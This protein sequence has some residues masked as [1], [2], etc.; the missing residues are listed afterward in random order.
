LIPAGIA[1]S[2]P[3]PW[4]PV[5]EGYKGV[6]NVSEEWQARDYELLTAAWREAVRAR[7]AADLQGDGHAGDSIPE[8]AVAGEDDSEP[9]SA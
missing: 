6:E 1:G 4:S 3:T 9:V 8:L 2:T 7:T 5:D